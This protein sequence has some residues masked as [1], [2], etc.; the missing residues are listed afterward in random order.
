[1]RS[2]GEYRDIRLSHD[3]NNKNEMPQVT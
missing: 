1:V 3:A 2:E